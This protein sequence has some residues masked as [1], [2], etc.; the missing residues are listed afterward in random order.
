MSRA[1]LD[2]RSQHSRRVPALFLSRDGLR[3]AALHRSAHGVEGGH[4][5]NHVG[6]ADRIASRLTRLVYVSGFVPLDGESLNDLTAQEYRIFFD[7]LA[8]DNGNVVILPFDIWRDSFMNDADLEV[9]RAS[10]AKLQ[11]QPYRTF[12]DCLRGY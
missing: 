5:R 4:G 10:Y 9:A 12:R 1:W 2:A 6:V 11:P 3:A 7:S 8:A